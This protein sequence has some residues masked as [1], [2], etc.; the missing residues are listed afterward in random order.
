MGCPSTR[1]RPTHT[2]PL[3]SSCR[4][5]A[6]VRS[7]SAVLRTERIAPDIIKPLAAENEHAFLTSGALCTHRV[8]DLRHK[9]SLK[10]C[11]GVLK[12]LKQT[13]D[14]KYISDK[15]KLFTPHMRVEIFK[16]E[17]IPDFVLCF[18]WKARDFHFPYWCFWKNILNFNQHQYYF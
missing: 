7:N 11:R 12:V 1:R 10:L 16:S 14:I 2:A 9:F 18:T 3:H 15:L 8:R 13:L 17:I 4:N 6:L 5:S